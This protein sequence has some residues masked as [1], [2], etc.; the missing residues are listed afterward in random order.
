[1]ARRQPANLYV[2]TAVGAIVGL[3]VFNGPSLA[4]ASW[5][6]RLVAAGVPG[7]ILGMAAALVWNKLR[8]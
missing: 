4:G 5:A 6:G 1:M 8:R 7:A 3:I 2:W